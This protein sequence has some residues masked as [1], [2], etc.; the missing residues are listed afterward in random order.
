MYYLIQIPVENSVPTLQPKALKP[1][2][3]PEV[4]KKLDTTLAK[5]GAYLEK[6]GAAQWWKRWLENARVHSTPLEPSD[7]EG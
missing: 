5:I 2:F 1:Y 3:D 6:S 4:L 7:L